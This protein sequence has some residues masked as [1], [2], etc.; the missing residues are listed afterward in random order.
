MAYTTLG[1]QGRNRG[2][3]LARIEIELTPGEE[4]SVRTEP[5]GRLERRRCRQ[6]SGST[7][8]PCWDVAVG[9]PGFDIDV[10]LTGT[11]IDR[12][13][14]AALDLRRTLE[15][16]TGLVGIADD[17]PYGKAEVLLELTPRGKALGFTT[18][19]V[20]D[21]AREIPGRHRGE[22]RAGRRR[23]DDPG[24]VPRSSAIAG[25]QACLLTLKSPGGVSVPLSEVVKVVEQQAFAVV[26]RREGKL[27]VSVTADVDG[28][29]T[30]PDQVIAALE[31]KALP[32]LRRIMG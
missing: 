4:R 13:K 10:R 29:I 12:L 1:Q 18:E 3:N 21:C 7:T 28:N 17:L 8:S 30:T 14:T 6:S 31:Q 20:S 32:D 11:S 23:G 26:Q 24:A 22:V 15:S 2:D 19:R 9:P 5:C 27:A 16:Y 25:S